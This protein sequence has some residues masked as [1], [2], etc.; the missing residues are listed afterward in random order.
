MQPEHH[1]R[2]VLAE[3][4]H[5]AA[6]GHYQEAL[7]NYLWIHEH[8]LDFGHSFAGVRLSFALFEWVGL[9]EKYPPARQAL[10]AVLSRTVAAIENGEGSFT[11]FHDVAAINRALGDDPATVR[12]FQWIHHRQPELAGKC[13]HV[14]ERVLTEAG[15][16]ATCICYVPDPAQRLEE[17]CQSRRMTLE[18][19][20]ENP[21]LGSPEAR[22]KEYADMKFAEETQRLIA[23]LEGVGRTGEADHV[24]EV[25]RAT[26]QGNG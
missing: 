26:G 10:L 16:Y 11:S 5:L 14:A 8:S 18:I 23:I 15:E 4:R 17:I 22:L 2:R 6:E 19:A 1:P 21:A 13:Y 7:A 12:L 3:A 20:E 25:A 24:R 9:G